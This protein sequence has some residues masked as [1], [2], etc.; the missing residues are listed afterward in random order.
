[1]N[2]DN[3]SLAGQLGKDRLQIATHNIEFSISGTYGLPKNDWGN[4]MM[5]LVQGKYYVPTAANCPVWNSCRV[6]SV[7]ATKFLGGEEDLSGPR[8]MVFQMT[9]AQ[10]HN[11][12][13]R[14]PNFKDVEARLYVFG[15]KA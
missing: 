11:L 15:R 1:M 7:R 10:G 5:P 13:K 2:C 12:G 3:S 4:D 9:I 14:H 8:L 6:M